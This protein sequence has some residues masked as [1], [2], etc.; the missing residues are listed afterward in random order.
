MKV[1]QQHNA[2]A[3]LLRRHVLNIAQMLPTRYNGTKICVAG[4][5]TVKLSV[6]LAATRITVSNTSTTVA[7]GSFR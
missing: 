6:A 1:N 7:V 5:N 4:S 3:V 2:N